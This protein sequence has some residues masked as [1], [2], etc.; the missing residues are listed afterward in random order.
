MR[1]THGKNTLEKYALMFLA[2]FCIFFFGNHVALSESSF[3]FDAIK[4]TVT[5]DLSGFDRVITPSN[6]SD[7]SSWFEG[8]NIDPDS[9]Q[10]FFQDEGILLK[11]VDEEGGRVLLI[12]ALA[13]TD[14]QMFF[15]LNEHEDEMRKNFRQSHSYNK[16]YNIIGYHY[17][18]ATWRNYGEGTDRFL[19]LKQSLTQE[20]EKVCSGYQRKTIRN[21]HTITVDLQIYDRSPK[22]SDERFLDKIIE[23]WEFT[24]ILTPPSDTVQLT[25]MQEPP[26]E[27]GETSFVVSGNTER[28][29][30]VTATLF[31][32]D[33]M[34]SS[35]FKDDTT[36][37]GSYKIEVTFPKEGL[38][39]LVLDATTADERTSQITYGINHQ[40]NYIPVQ[41]L[42][43]IPERVHRDSFVL[44]GETAEYTTVQ[45]TIQGPVEQ[46][47][48]DGGPSFSFDVDMSKAGVYTLTMI[49]T[50]K[51]FDT[52][53]FS[54]TIE[55]VMTK[56]EALNKFKQS[57][58][59]LEYRTLRAKR[60]EYS[61]VAFTYTGYIVEIEKTGPEWTITFALSKS[62]ET[63]KNMVYL[64]AKEDI[65][66]GVGD[67]VTMYGT[68]SA[69]PYILTVDGDMYEY[70]RF[71]LSL[72][73]AV[74]E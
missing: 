15:D 42:Q 57:A 30:T 18:S 41:F 5:A 26:S 8:Q 47:L 49:V 28:A 61:D 48:E 24:E 72:F 58:K 2:V 68:L 39:S 38:F 22:S 56:E 66:F 71:D 50:K 21:G 67:K 10:V 74:A 70:P 43:A 73:E 51:D 9:M 60:T 25:V 23:N 52:R 20:G 19:R 32:V 40:K 36:S 12:T 37:D 14:G 3:V 34:K 54:Y 1:N 29:A 46:H 45:L 17:D 69:H 11:A 6:L 62:G 63:Y 59:T 64:I 27:T 13:D 7:H 65:A 16:V 31:T 35:T 33:G 53:S 55:R 44:S 4:T